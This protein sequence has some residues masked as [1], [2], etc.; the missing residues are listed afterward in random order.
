MLNKSP[1]TRALTRAGEFPVVMGVA[2]VE[3]EFFACLDKVER[4]KLCPFSKN[5]HEGIRC[6]RVIDEPE[7]C[8]LFACID[9]LP[10]IHFDN[11][12]PLLGLG[13]LS[14]FS[15]RDEFPFL[16]ADFLPWSQGDCGE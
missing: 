6:A 15:L 14:P 12:N 10:V 2:I 1:A 9:R 13:A 5:S 16:L 4:V 11:G 7:S 3:R 8:R